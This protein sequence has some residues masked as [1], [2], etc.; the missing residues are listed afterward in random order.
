[1]PQAEVRFTTPNLA[2]IELPPRNL[3]GIY[4][5]IKLRKFA[6]QG[7]RLMVFVEGVR[8]EVDRGVNRLFDEL[9]KLT[10]FYMEVTAQG[11]GR[12]QGLP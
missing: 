11:Y 6:E 7:N 10:I 4:A 5:R 2:I 3:G 1:M 8:V 9:T 12:I